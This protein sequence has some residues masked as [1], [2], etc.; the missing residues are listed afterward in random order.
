MELP[1]KQINQLLGQAKNILLTGSKDPSVDVLSTAYAWQFFLSGQNKKVDLVFDGKIDSYNFLPKKIKVSQDLGNLNKFKIIL[2]TKDAKVRQLSYD[3]GDNQ[4]TINLVS[5]DGQFS[6]KD[7]SS[8]QGDY[9]YDLIIVLGAESLDALGDIFSENRNFFHQTTIINIDHSVLNENYGQLNLVESNATS[10][11]EISYHILADNLS[12]DIATCLLAGMI[13]ATNSF[14]SPKVTPSTLELASQLIIKG[15][16]REEI[17][18]S[19]Y[20]TKDIATLK[21]WGKVLSRLRKQGS[22]ISSYLKHDEEES[23]PQDFEEM[24]RELILSTPEAQL[25]VIFYQAELYQTEVWIYTI[26]NIDALD[27]VR[28]MPA[29][30]YR[31]LAKLTLQEDLRTT[32]E[33]ILDRLAKKL[34]VINSP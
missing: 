33:M 7:V 15:A 29:T 5:E 9:K 8:E 19:L 6:A 4:L 32:R 34:E 31:R 11:A 27:L 17:I 30:G 3:V 20:R 28:G 16:R 10:L 13:A 2:N 26:A 23:L 12:A 14:Q 21:S 22:I 25:A 24:I 1:K 18:N